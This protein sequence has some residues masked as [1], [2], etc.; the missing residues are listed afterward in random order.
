[1]RP[2][3]IFTA[4]VLLYITYS[5]SHMY[6]IYIRY[7]AL[8]WYPSNNSVRALKV[9]SS[10]TELWEGCHT[11]LAQ[12]KKKVLAHGENNEV[13]FITQPNGVNKRKRICVQAGIPGFFFN[14]SNR[15]AIPH[16]NF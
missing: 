15:T 3:N 1:M 2:R 11:N 12:S 10:R 8:V 16:P 13:R 14:H 5:V 7:L 9:E 6:I 4:F